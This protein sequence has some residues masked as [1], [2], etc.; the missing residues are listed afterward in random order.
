[1]TRMQPIL[2]TK[3]SQVPHVLYSELPKHLTKII[4]VNEIM[5]YNKNVQ[6]RM[7]NVNQHLFSLYNPWKTI[8]PSA[9]S[10]MN[11]KYPNTILCIHR[12]GTQVFEESEYYEFIQKYKI[13]NCTQ[14]YDPLFYK[15]DRHLRYLQNGLDLNVIPVVML[16]DS[17]FL[18]K[19]F[20]LYSD[21][22]LKTII[23]ENNTEKSLSEFVDLLDSVKS[24]GILPYC[25]RL[26]NYEDVK[27][28]RSN[29]YQYDTYICEHLAARRK[30]IIDGEL[31][32]LTDVA[33]G[34]GKAPMEK[35]CDCEG[36]YYSSFYVQHLVNSRELLA[37]VCL[38]HH[39]LSKLIK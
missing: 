12:Q 4:Y 17:N 19:V 31:R 18:S 3:Q 10:A 39:N 25:I 1:M 11:S 20:E 23:F 7:E 33:K 28:C 22:S 27:L 37:E 21:R 8:T 36:C 13:Q 9:R 26:T 16:S 2:Q 29:E 34:N 35:G 30:V 24:K 6:I 32:N 38:M 14:L 5:D 15:K